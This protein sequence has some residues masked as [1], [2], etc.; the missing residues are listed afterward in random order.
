M[1]K[2]LVKDK[3]LNPRWK[4]TLIFEISYSEDGNIPPLEVFIK[5]K[6]FFSDDDLGSVRIDLTP[7]I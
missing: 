4:E 2:T 6:D 3:T 5:D 7:V 1:G